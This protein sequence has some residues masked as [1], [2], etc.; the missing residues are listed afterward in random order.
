MKMKKDKEIKIWILVLSS[1]L[2]GS[3]FSTIIM[4]L[5]RPTNNSVVNKNTLKNNIESSVYIET[6]TAGLKDSNGSGFIYKTDLNN[7]YIITNEHVIEG[8]EIVVMNNK[9]EET[10]ATLLGKD[11]YLDLAILKISRKYASKKVV[12]AKESP[13]VGEKVYVIG[14]PMSKNY[15]NSVTSGVLSGKNRLVKT[16]VD[17]NEANWVMESLQYDAPI[18][19]GNSGGALLN[20]NGDV[21][22]IVTMK[23]IQ[24]DIEGMAFAIPIEDALK[25]VKDLEQG[26]DIKYPEIGIS[27]ADVTSTATITTKGISIPDVEEGVV[28]LDVKKDSSAASAK[29][30]KGDIIISINGNKTKDMAYFK[31]ELYKYSEK[32]KIKIKYLRNNKEKETTLTINKLK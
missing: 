30:K 8:K 15:L 22:G 16:S 28:I 17:G 3:I 26:K 9:K 11:P 14:T 24:E 6:R 29:L 21:I 4:L 20:S 23:L 10:K 31:H 1:F 32:D 5:L 7:A 19:P 2:V 13:K 12:I 18:N 25:H 27:M